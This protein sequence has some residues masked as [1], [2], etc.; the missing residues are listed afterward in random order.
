MDS[1]DLP[2]RNTDTTPSACPFRKMG[3]WMK[4]IAKIAFIPSREFH[5][6][7]SYPGIV[8]RSYL[9]SLSSDC[10]LPIEETEES[11]AL[12]PGARVLIL[13]AGGGEDLVRFLNRGYDA[14]GVEPDRALAR[15]TKVCLEQMGIEP[16][17]MMHV[18]GLAIP[19][20]LG[21]FDLI[22]FSGDYYSRIIGNRRRVAILKDLHRHML[23]KGK[24]YF[25][26]EMRPE[27]G[28]G[29]S[30]YR[31][32]P[33]VLIQMIRSIMGQTDIRIETGVRLSPKVPQLK[34]FFLRHEIVA[35]MAECG[36]AVEE[37]FTGGSGSALCRKSCPLMQEHVGLDAKV[38]EAVTI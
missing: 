35:E 2:H 25:E 11:L 20:N 17:K 1:S 13:G 26:F 21:Q 14:V 23:P 34:H 7:T 22:C 15:K 16:A 37:L 24:L 38:L 3:G 9:E 12:K 10:F 36:F 6:H 29:S 32:M 27:K 19:R 8:D 5:A 31:F 28:N 4:E 18:E 30:G 33:V